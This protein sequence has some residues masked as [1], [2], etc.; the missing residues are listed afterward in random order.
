MRLLSH[1]L[2]CVGLFEAFT[3]STQPSACYNLTG[4]WKN[5]KGSILKIVQTGNH[6]RGSFS[7]AVETVEGAAGNE[8]VHIRGFAQCGLI[9]F[10][11]TYKDSVA[12]FSGQCYG[13]PL[14]ETL[15][16]TW[17]LHSRMPDYEN[18]WM[19]TRI[20]QDEFKLVQTYPYTANESTKTS[21]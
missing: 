10:S 18:Y 9:S 17:L 20:G 14:E 19:G 7:T 3:I 5:S 1:L 15:Y 8:P 13:K 12:S 21:W 16:T 4:G 6:I 2:L 11:V